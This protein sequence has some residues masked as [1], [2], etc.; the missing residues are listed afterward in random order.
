MDK[1]NKIFDDSCFK[2][3]TKQTSDD[4]IYIATR[5]IDSLIEMFPDQTGDNFNKIMNTLT[6]SLILFIINNIRNDKQSFVLE[7]LV[8]MIKENLKEMNKQ[9]QND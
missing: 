5:I 6:A 3:V 1:I 8:I 9:M 4:Y 7:K 2:E